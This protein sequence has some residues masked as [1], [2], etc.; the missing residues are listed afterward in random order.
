[1]GELERCPWCGV[2]WYTKPLRDGSTLKH[3][4]DLSTVARLAYQR[5]LEA[6]ARICQGKA[7]EE[8]AEVD[9]LKRIHAPEDAVSISSIRCMNFNECAAAIRAAKGDEK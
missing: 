3:T 7:S 6:A 8:R 5:G 1:M 9:R 4:C 2:E